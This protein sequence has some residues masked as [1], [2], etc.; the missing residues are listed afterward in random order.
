M[1]AR[2]RG[3]QW[4]DD[5]LIP[6]REL[7]PKVTAPS[8]TRVCIDDPIFWSEFLKRLS[9][10]DVEYD[11]GIIQSLC[12]ELHVPAEAVIAKMKTTMFFANPSTAQH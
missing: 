10:C 3:D 4:R 2:S 7:L 9:F 8:T 1:T 6:Y 12:K 11:V 5:I